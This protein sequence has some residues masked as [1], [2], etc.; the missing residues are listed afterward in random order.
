M[1]LK[2]GFMSTEELAEWAD[3]SA[4]YLKNKKAA[5][6]QKQLSRH[7]E[8]ELKRGGVE[9]LKIF[10]DTYMSS[11][12]KEIHQKYYDYWGNGVDKVDT[13]KNCWEKLSPHLQMN[14]SYDS[15]YSALCSCRR[16]DYGG[17]RKGKRFTGTKGSCYYVYCKREGNVLSLFSEEELKLKKELQQKYLKTDT[18]KVEEQVII[19]NLWKKGEITQ[20]EYDI[21]FQEILEQKNNWLTFQNAFEEELGCLTDY[22]ILLVDYEKSAWEVKPVKEDAFEF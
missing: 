1:V 3:V 17:P 9:I 22:G 11:G 6:C 7:A 13:N 20:E 18:Q 5:W 4:A 14:I 2:L 12:R 16:E 8:Y 19:Y 15:G 10:Q 21:K